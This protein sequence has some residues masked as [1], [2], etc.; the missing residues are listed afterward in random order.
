MS[1]KKYCQGEF[2]FARPL[3]W[4]RVYR[5]PLKNLKSQIVER[6]LNCV[7]ISI[8]S[9]QSSFSIS[10]SSSYLFVCLFVRIFHR[11]KGLLQ[12]G[13]F[14]LLYGPWSFDLL[15]KEFFSRHFL[16]QKV[17]GASMIILFTMLHYL[18]ACLH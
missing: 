13:E 15:K 16:G 6:V 8:F 2:T 14:L 17:G 5:R 18:A 12:K 1:N 11:V 9:Q 7:L 4:K 10:F 3:E